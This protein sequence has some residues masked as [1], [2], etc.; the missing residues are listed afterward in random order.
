LA[1]KP[2]SEW[3]ED[4][5]KRIESAE[6]RGL[7]RAEA[8]GHPEEQRGAV[9]ASLWADVERAAATAVDAQVVEGPFGPGGAWTVVYV[10]VDATGR[11]TIIDV[12]KG[13]RMT[14]RQRD[15]LKA[16]VRRHLGD[17]DLHIPAIGTP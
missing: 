3:T 7:T 12:A 14:H 17:R 4:Y 9:G 11:E 10:A 15:D 13:V 5:R 2:R 6:A 8:R 16:R 1:R